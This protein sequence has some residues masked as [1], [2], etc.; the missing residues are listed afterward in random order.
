MDGV[1][2]GSYL[3]LTRLASDLLGQEAQEGLEDVLGQLMRKQF[4]SRNRE[5]VARFFEGMDLVEP[6][7]VR[8][9]EWRP[10]TE[11]RGTG[12]SS[13]WCAAGRKA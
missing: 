11:M 5:Q 12:G 13:L 7:L 2:V 8:V 3:A 6:G 9:E 10:D 4:T 1:P